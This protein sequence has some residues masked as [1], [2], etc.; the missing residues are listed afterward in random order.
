MKIISWNVNGLRSVHG[1]GL[2]KWLRQAKPD[3]FCLQEIKVSK[4]KIPEK[5]L[6]LSGYY[7][8]FSHARRPGY[9]GTAIYTKL[10]PIS[11][12][13]EM[14]FEQFDRE[15]RF[16]ALDFKNFILINVYLPQGGRMKEK[17]G[18]K[19]VAYKKLFNYLRTIGAKKSVILLGDFNIA[20]TALDLARPK[21][22]ENNIMFT[23]AERKQIDRLEALGFIDTFREFHKGAGHYTWW[24]Y[25]ANVRAKNIGW[26]IDYVFANKLIIKKISKAFILPAVRGSD[27]CPIGIN[28][29]P[30]K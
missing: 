29:N 8:Y 23:P 10:K 28:F 27:H 17:L 13:Y 7:A 26:R 6:N 19:L 9:S 21:P 2:L 22:N 11:A 20:H 4:E 1:K 3:I 24:S 16:L 12:R 25:R 5:L 30:V 15:G 18:Y 14:G